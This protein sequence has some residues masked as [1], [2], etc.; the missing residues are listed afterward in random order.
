VIIV[1]KADREN[2]GGNDEEGR[3]FVHRFVEVE[4][5][6]NHYF[7]VFDAKGKYIKKITVWNI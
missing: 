7:D 5:S 2:T 1:S 3:I 4:K 6:T